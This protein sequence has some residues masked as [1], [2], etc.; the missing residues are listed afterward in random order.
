M[1]PKMCIKALQRGTCG[2]GQVGRS[3][4]G[5]LRGRAQ[6]FR[7]DL[8]LGA[9]SP[10]AVEEVFNCADGLFVWPINGSGSINGIFRFGDACF[11]AWE[12]LRD[13]VGYCRSYGWSQF[14]IGENRG[15]ISRK[16]Q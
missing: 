16:Q 6:R 14:S 5:L 10:F 9:A 3:A 1:L 8:E 7:S 4:L 15:G 2:E 13:R 11:N 12:R